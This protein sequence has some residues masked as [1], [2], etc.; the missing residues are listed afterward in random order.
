MVISRLVN[1]VCTTSAACT[2]CDV[3]VASV[4]LVVQGNLL[5]NKK[6]IFNSCD[7]KTEKRIKI[8]VLKEII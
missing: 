4:A 8:N 6:T 1:I 3:H 2:I 5:K 7:K